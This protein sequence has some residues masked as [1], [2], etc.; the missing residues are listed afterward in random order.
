MR[1]GK[2]NEKPFEE[3]AEAEDMEMYRA[4]MALPAE[5]GSLAAVACATPHPDPLCQFPEEIPLSL[6]VN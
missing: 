5:L 6:G 2:G 4:E 3:R 1:L